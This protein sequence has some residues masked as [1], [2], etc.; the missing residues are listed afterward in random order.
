MAK[1]NRNKRFLWADK[2]IL[3]FFRQEFGKKTWKKL[4]AV[5]LA[6]CEID[7]DLQEGILIKSLIKTVQDY[8]GYGEESVLNCLEIL[9]NL[10]LVT[11]FQTR[12]E[13][14]F[15]KTKLILYEFLETSYPGIPGSVNP[16]IRKSPDPEKPGY[17][18]A[19]KSIKKQQFIESQKVQKN[20][21]DNY[22]Y[23]MSLKN[24]KKINNIY[25]CLANFLYQIVHQKKNIR[26]TKKTLTAWAGE[27]RKLHEIN[28]VEIKR[29][30]K[31]LIWYKNN[32]GGAYVPVVE[33]GSSLRSKFLR[34][35][36]A[37]ERDP[38]FRKSKI[39]KNIDQGKD[40]EFFDIEINMDELED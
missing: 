23:N 14:R 36:A 20:N 16:R 18:G 12:K 6:L 11:Y 9:K 32:I 19:S 30:K 22:I 21:P 39:A 26:F 10:G 7:S 13:G 15:S 33:S 2:Q 38:E 1:N 24:N 27:I 40:Q 3:K 8:S 34:L 5:Y 4:Q 17:G 29:I 25:I 28:Q 37:M 35:E 31:V